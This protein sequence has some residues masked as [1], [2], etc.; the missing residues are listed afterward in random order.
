M[1]RR[2]DGLLYLTVGA[3]GSGK[4]AWVHRR[5]AKA[6]RVMAWD[7]EGQH[8]AGAEIIRDRR[9]LAEVANDSGPGRYAFIPS[10]VKDFDFWARCAFLWVR[11]APGVVVAEELAD[12]TTPGKAPDGW[13][14]LVRRGRKY[15]ADIYA[16]TQRPAESDK[17]AV[18]NAAVIH[19]CRMS[20]AK[21]RAY[22]ADELDIDR[23]ELAGLKG[24]DW[25][26]KDMRT[27]KIKRGTLTF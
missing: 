25:I 27:G 9:R 15:G 14:M 24:L 23:R 6:R 2:R 12:V 18:G 20:R 8:T 16:I 4:T 19:C 11:R 26:E 3:S 22:M 17:T 10:S 13:G 1:A 5:I 21:D 7:I